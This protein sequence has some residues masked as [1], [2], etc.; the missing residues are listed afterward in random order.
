V[1]QSANAQAAQPAPT[2]EVLRLSADEAAR[3][4]AANN[5]DLVAGGYDPRIGA[6]RVAQASAAFLPTLSSGIVR[7]VQQAPP[8]SVFFGTEGVRTD[9]WSGNIGLGQRLPVGGGAYSVGWSSLRTNASNSLSNFNPSVTAQLQAVYTQPLLRDF[10]IDQARAQVTLARQT[11][12]IADIGL[13]E[14]GT[15]V[16]ASAERAYWNLVLSRANVAV[17]Q[18]SLDLS[19]ELER[20][21]R[22]RVDVGQSP[23]LDL[24]SARAEVAQRRE[25]LIVA[26]TLVRQAEDQLRVLILDPKRPDY[27][28]VRLDPADTIPPVGPA[29]DVDAAVRNALAQRTDLE[30]TRRQIDINDTNVSLTK[31]A[32][33]PDVRVQ[34]SYLTN[35]LGGTEILRNGF[36]GPILGQ[37]FVAFG[38]VLGQLF[39]ANYPTWQVGLTFSYPLGRSA[40]QAAFARAKLEREQNVERLRSAEFKVVREVRQAA[41][42]L[43]QN[44]QRIETT[45]LARE[46]SEQRLDAEQKRFDVG[47]STNFNV[48]QAQRD[49]AVSRNSEL[50][51]QLDYQQAWI[52]FE[53]VQKVGGTSATTVTTGT[54]TA[55]VGTTTTPSGATVTTVTGATGPGGQ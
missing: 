36:L 8:S 6:E 17:Q 45:R 32:T 24:V 31:N 14:L 18:R 51:A 15:T 48:I 12:R 13:Q 19:L 38:D 7:N 47:M 9:V 21:N 42:Q 54:G 40:D 30:R 1:P 34:A 37:D 3:M 2:G 44:R 11:E 23:P 50:Q 53:T 27:W 35:G 39:S 33:L 16:T 22:A 46:L 25:T 49:L 55:T 43:D 10:K 28:Y 41:L 52:N 20:N 29:P 5:P 4:A 26:Q